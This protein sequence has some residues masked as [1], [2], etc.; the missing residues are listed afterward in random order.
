MINGVPVKERRLEHGDEI[1]IGE[2]ILLFLLYEPEITSPSHSVEFGDSD[3]D[4]RSMVRLPVEKSILFNT[5]KLV[6]DLASPSRVL[7]DMQELLKISTSINSY[8]RLEVLQ[9]E[10]LNSLF[11]IIPADAG[12][13]IALRDGLD[14]V[15][16]SF[17]LSRTGC[18]DVSFSISRTVARQVISE[19]ISILSNNVS[20]AA[21][22]TEA[23]SLILS[24]TKSLLCVPLSNGSK[25]SGFIYLSSSA[26][27]VLFDERHLELASAVAG[28]AS[29][30][31]E[32]ARYLEWLSDERQRLHDELSLKHA[33]IGQS[34]RMRD[35]LHLVAK[36]SPTNATVL[37]RGESGTGKELVARAIHANSPRAD[38]S[39]I[40]I[41]CATLSETLLESELFGHERGAF[42]G[43]IAQ[44]KGKL[45]IADGGTL[46]LDE[47]GEINLPLQAKLLRVLQERTFERVG[48]HRSISVD[49]RVI[50]ATNRDLQ[51]AITHGT[52]RDELY[53]RLNVVT[54]DIPPLRERREDIPLLA[55]YFAKKYGNSCNR[56]IDGVSPEASACLMSHDWPG[57][58]RELE[59]AIERA[60]VL[61]RDN[62]IAPDDLPETVRKKIELTDTPSPA[63]YHALKD[64]K[65]QLILDALEQSRGNYVEAAKLL[66][67]HPNNLHRLV[68]TLNLK[69]NSAKS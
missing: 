65:K 31:I 7:R 34:K 47:V 32:N 45:E 58:V 4:T 22:Y 44:K 33:M 28:I 57:N 63:F 29:I 53:Y 61:G 49:I 46:F 35:V 21:E 23:A 48:G 43:A 27:D 14:Q 51:D 30:A 55:R 19:N 18:K 3:L 67:I 1:T 50:A 17:T 9:E 2:S 41:N 66:G 56:H 26:P 42:T 54:I 25:V 5:E 11:E 59:N 64:T 36:V 52:F 8:R 69:S 40:A 39:F 37:I 68:R 13:I 10:L 60:V 62:I 15:S 24:Q 12:A 38:K 20:E 6:G 16:D